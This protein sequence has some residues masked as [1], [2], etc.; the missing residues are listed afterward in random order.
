MRR[1]HRRDDGGVAVRA[2]GARGAGGQR[3][4]GFGHRTSLCGRRAGGL[5][6]RSHESRW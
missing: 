3:E 5:R 1:A 2:R 6:P 4:G